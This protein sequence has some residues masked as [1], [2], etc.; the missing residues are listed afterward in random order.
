MNTGT[1]WIID[2]D[3]DDHNVVREIWKEMGFSND[4]AFFDS[5]EEAMHRLAQVSEAPF[6]ILC[7]VNLPG[8]NGFSL[9][10]Q[11][12]DANTNSFKS[13][14]FIFWSEESAEAQIREA[15]D[16]SAHGFFVKD[17]SMEEWK[18]TFSLIINY[19]RKSK[20]PSKKAE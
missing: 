8:T 10:R 18:A 9:R 5:A 12:L 7:D 20:I 6:I 11:M 14:P 17:S 16:L 13:V 15:Y 19:W 1:V 2:D 3:V 4:L